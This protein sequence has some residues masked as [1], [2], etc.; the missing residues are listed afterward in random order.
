[1]ALP[2]PKLVDPLKDAAAKAE[3]DKQALYDAALFEN[4][5]KKR[6]AELATTALA[7]LQ[8]KHD[9]LAAA[10][11]AS[12]T[13]ANN[14]LAKLKADSDKA[15]A[16]AAA[17]GAVLTRKIDALT[18]VAQHL[19][20]QLGPL[21]VSLNQGALD[22]QAAI[23]EKEKAGEAGAESKFVASIATLSDSIAKAA[24]SATASLAD[25]AKL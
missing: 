16:D 25:A 9:T 4:G 1:M 6:E 13:D 2:P 11:N 5:M 19:V 10:S 7:A 20:A 14:A 12:I 22:F 17:S 15:A 18:A 24:A 3:A 8:A 23:A 21:C